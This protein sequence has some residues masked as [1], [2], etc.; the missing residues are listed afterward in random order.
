MRSGRIRREAVP[1]AA[2]A[3][4]VRLTD[5]TS[6]AA[7]FTAETGIRR[8]SSLAWYDAPSP[9]PDYYRWMPGYQTD[10]VTRLEMENIWRANDVRY[11]QIDW[12]EFY[13]QNRNSKDGSATYLMEDRRAHR[14]YP[15]RGRRY[16]NQRTTDGT[17]RHPSGPDGLPVL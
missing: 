8:Y 13:R 17:L 12:D 6:L 9:M 11:T 10:P 2:A 3:Y 4:R 7:T 16:P 14:Q 5:A 15:T 1:L